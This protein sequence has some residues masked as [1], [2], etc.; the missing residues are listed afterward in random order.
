MNFA[1]GFFASLSRVGPVGGDLER[2]EFEEG[3]DQDFGEEDGGAGV[4]CCRRGWRSRSSG[5]SSERSV[6][7]GSGRWSR[8]GGCRCRGSRNDR[9]GEIVFELFNLR[10]ES[11]QLVSAQFEDFCDDIA[12]DFGFLFDDGFSDGDATTAES[13]LRDASCCFLGAEHDDLD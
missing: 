12:F 1:Y 2:V 11:V 9:S 4:D 10:F 6:G 3:L 5:G 13:V 8:G 7:G